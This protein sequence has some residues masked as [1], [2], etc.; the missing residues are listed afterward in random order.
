MTLALTLALG[1]AIGLVMGLTGAGGGVL[2]VPALVFGLGLTMPQAAPI[3]MV[4]VALAASVGAIEGLRR[5][6]V[7]YRAAMFIAVMGW[8]LSALGVALAH[9][10]P[11]LWLR[12]VFVLLLAFVAWRQLH[13]TAQAARAEAEVDEP[14]PGAVAEVDPATG[15]FIWNRRTFSSFAGIGAVTGFMSGLLGVSGGFVLVPLLSHFTRLEAPALVGTS[16]MVGAL[17]TS[18]GALASALQ[19]VAISWSVAGWFAAALV[20]G[21]LAARRVSR[22]LPPRAMHDTFVALV[23]F[24]AIA[25]AIDVARR[26]LFL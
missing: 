10:L 9:R 2:A 11:D 7:R 16:L 21:M 26:V 3:A 22:R 14:P 18:F 17:V 13:V 20:G 15:R 25:M 5:G 23:I 6:T 1:L 8:P 19:G 12:I 24:V 4:G